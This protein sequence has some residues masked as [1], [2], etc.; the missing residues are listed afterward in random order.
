M[1]HLKIIRTIADTKVSNVHS[2]FLVSMQK[3]IYAAKIGALT[4][5]AA[6]S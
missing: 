5:A 3:L 6:N 2:E 4:R 1:L